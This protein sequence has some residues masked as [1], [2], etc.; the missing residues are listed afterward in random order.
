MNI[1]DRTKFTKTAFNQKVLFAI[2]L[3]FFYS[4]DPGSSIGYRILNKTKSPLKVKYRFTFSVASDTLPKEMLIPPE[5]AIILYRM[6]HIGYVNDIDK[7]NDSI[8]FYQ[9]TLVQNGKQSNLN[10]K[11][12]KL[13]KL[14]K[15]NDQNATYLLIVDSN[16]FR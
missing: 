16:Y 1:Q 10:L 9:L 4:C 3:F 2:F 6:R 13:W 11:N 14:K 12:K 5:S 7:V 15:E 8:Y